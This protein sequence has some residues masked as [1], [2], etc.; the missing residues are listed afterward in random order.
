MAVVKNI[1]IAGLIKF[2]EIGLSFKWQN[3]S[4]SLQVSSANSQFATAQVGCMP[5]ATDSHRSQLIS[6]YNRRHIEYALAWA[7][8]QTAAKSIWVGC[9]DADDDDTW[10]DR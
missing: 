4:A 8:Y 9:D 1:N 3:F 2:P 7:N 5:S 10:I 6:P